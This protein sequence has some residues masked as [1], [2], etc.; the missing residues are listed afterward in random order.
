ME[1]EPQLKTDRV[2]RFIPLPCTSPVRGEITV[3][4]RVCASGKLLDRRSIFPSRKTHW[5]SK[6]SNREEDSGRSGEAP[7]ALSKRA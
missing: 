2:R 3:I 6:R 7:A 5:G 1:G 4:V